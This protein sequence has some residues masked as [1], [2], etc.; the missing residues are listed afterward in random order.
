MRAWLSGWF[1]GLQPRERWIVATAALLFVIIIGWRLVLS[2]LRAEIARLQTSVDTK[3]QL[4]IDV[5]RVEA[6][7]PSTVPDGLIGLDQPLVQL[8]PN[9]AKT[10][11][12]AEPRARGNGPSGVD[13]TLQNASFDAVAVWLVALHDQYGVDVETASFTP[14]REPGIV[15]A[16]VLLRRP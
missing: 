3:Q 5:R 15:N 2:P 12:L 11:G 4:L 8:I 7:R 14:T 1:Y 6:D 10:Y 13:V 9:T 16:S